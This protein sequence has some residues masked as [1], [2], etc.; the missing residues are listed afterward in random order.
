[1]HPLPL[2]SSKASVPDIE[3]KLPAYCIGMVMVQLMGPR[4][5]SS[6]RLGRYFGV[7]TTNYVVLF[8]IKSMSE[9]SMQRSLNCT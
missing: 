8:F 2:T 4:R 3:E 7:R 9:G 5:I 1:M 6:N